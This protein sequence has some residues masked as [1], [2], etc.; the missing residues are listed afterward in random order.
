MECPQ[1]TVL[2]MSPPH[3]KVPFLLFFLSFFFLL[4]FSFSPDFVASCI[5]IFYMFS[6]FI[7]L[8]VKAMLEHTKGEV[9]FFSYILIFMDFIFYFQLY[10]VCHETSRTL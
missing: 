5:Q 7:D 1:K 8:F 9:D 2:L 6:R 3:E 4:S 10:F